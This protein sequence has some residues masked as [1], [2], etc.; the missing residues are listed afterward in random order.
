MGKKK[1]SSVEHSVEELRQKEA[2]LAKE[3][4]ALKNELSLNR[5]LEQPHLLRE[6]KRERARALTRLTEIAK[7]EIH[8]AGK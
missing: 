8:A 4:F 7:G 5:K 6:K 2:L 3:I 1:K